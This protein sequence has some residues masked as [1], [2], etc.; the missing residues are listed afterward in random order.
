MAKTEKYFVGPQLLG[1]IRDTIDRVSGLSLSTSGPSF[2]TSFQELRRP[3]GGLALGKVTATWNKNSLQE[4]ILYNQGE[5]L[6]ETSSTPSEKIVDCVNKIIR[7][8]ANKWV[9]IGRM[10]SRWYLVNAECG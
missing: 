1:E 6:L 2:S 8:P 7:V 4:V 9:I 10:N 5:G 3:S